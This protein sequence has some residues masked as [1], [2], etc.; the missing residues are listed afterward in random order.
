ML[1]R[2]K[3]AAREVKDSHLKPKV[4]Q[5]TKKASEFQTRKQGGDMPS[6]TAAAG[7]LTKKEETEV[8]EEGRKKG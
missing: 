6:Q 7:A 1:R 3:N 5:A 8:T 4:S 2:E